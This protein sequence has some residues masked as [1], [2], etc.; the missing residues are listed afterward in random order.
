MENRWT[1]A[2]GNVRPKSGSQRSETEARRLHFLEQS[3][4][5]QEAQHTIER[6]GVHPGGGR[7]LV[8]GSRTVREQTRNIEPC[9]DVD[10]LGDAIAGDQLIELI[11]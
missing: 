6:A 5:C 11:E 10:R 9:H 3:N 4:T 7:E 2:G 8:A 1:H